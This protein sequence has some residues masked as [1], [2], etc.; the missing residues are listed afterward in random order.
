MLITQD[1]TFTIDISADGQTVEGTVT[2]MTG[3]KCSDV[4]KI[5]NA[6]GQ[7]VEHRHTG[8]YDKTEPVR[9]NAKPTVTIGGWKR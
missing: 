9:I 6:L 8:D 4:S 2:G 3:H 1:F 7:E 5:L